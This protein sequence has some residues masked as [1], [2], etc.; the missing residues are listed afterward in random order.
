MKNLSCFWISLLVFPV[1]LFISNIA[2]LFTDGSFGYIKILMFTNIYFFAGLLT[3][4]F[5]FRFERSKKPVTTACEIFIAAVISASACIAAGKFSI[6]IPILSL[7][8]FFAGFRYYML[9]YSHFVNSNTVVLSSTSYI[10]VMAIFM[11]SDIT[12][13][14]SIYYSFYVAAIFLYFILNNQANIVRLTSAKNYDEKNISRQTKNYNIRMVLLICAGICVLMIFSKQAAWLISSTGQTLFGLLAHLLYWITSLFTE[15]YTP[16]DNPEIKKIKHDNIPTPD[17]NES[18]AVL[19]I[20]FAAVFIIFLIIRF[21]RQTA[22]ILKQPLIFIICLIR[23]IFSDKKNINKNEMYQA[24]TDDI[25]TLTNISDSKPILS[26]RRQISK[27]KKNY[28]GLSETPDCRNAY[29][30]AAQAMIILGF[31]IKTSDTPFEVIN[32]YNSKYYSSACVYNKKRY[33]S[34]SCSKSELD[35]LMSLLRELDQKLSSYRKHLII[36]NSHQ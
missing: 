32:K 23:K 36:K 2:G 13:V 11:V 9:D 3:R 6:G 33:S 15:Q 18:M 5:F 8:L 34:E 16:E 12:V 21:R 28:S 24:Y 29:K 1:V 27:W 31:D 19:F 10:V 35:C 20:I 4:F 17:S 25:E 26:K 30:L 22:Y 7:A 14:K